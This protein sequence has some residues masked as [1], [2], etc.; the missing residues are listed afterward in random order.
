MQNSDGLLQGFLHVIFVKI[1]LEDIKNIHVMVDTIA[2]VMII[3]ISLIDIQGMRLIQAFSDL[4]ELLD[5]AQVVSMTLEKRY[6]II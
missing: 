3:V 6:L 4:L 1:A 2:R 5:V